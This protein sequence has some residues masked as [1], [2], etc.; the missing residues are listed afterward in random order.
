MPVGY[1]VD[2]GVKVESWQVRVLGL[3]VDHSGKVVPGQVNI[4]GKAVVQIWKANPVFRSDWLTNDNLVNV[5]KLIPIIVPTRQG[6]TLTVSTL[7]RM[8]P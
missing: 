4:Q 2:E 3:D 6:H 7:H 8:R 5:I 1:R